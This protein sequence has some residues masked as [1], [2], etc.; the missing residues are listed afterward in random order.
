MII[1]IWKLFLSTHI[2]STALQFPRIRECITC[3]SWFPF[4]PR[5]SAKTFQPRKARRRPPPP[6]GRRGGGSRRGQTRWTE[7]TCGC[8]RGRWKGGQTGRWLKKNH[9][10]SFLRGVLGVVR[11][12]SGGLLFI[13]LNTFYCILMTMFF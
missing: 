2:F 1:C 13:C 6:R 5:G 9:R 3:S 7:W 10:C 12:S 8:R 11:K 4:L